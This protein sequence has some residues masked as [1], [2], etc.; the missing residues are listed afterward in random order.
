MRKGLKATS[1]FLL[2]II[3]LGASM[4]AAY[5]RPEEQARIEVGDIIVIK[6]LRGRAFAL[7]SNSEEPV[8]A[9]MTIECEV[10]S[11]E[12][13]LVSAEIHEGNITIQEN[14]FDV[15]NG[16]VRARLGKFGWILIRG[17]TIVDDKQYRFRFEGMLHVEKPG[18]VV[19]GLVGGLRG[20]ELSYRINGIGRAIKLESANNP[21]T[22]NL[23]NLLPYV[24]AISGAGL[25]SN[26]H[27]SV[28]D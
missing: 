2:A 18:L 9:T 25:L 26:F 16:T 11:V 23:P 24:H 3:L 22:I 19:I 4:S 17:L 13:R 14:R 1:L 10:V 27:L 8:N 28:V 5:S 6:F 21:S 7:E 12:N 20:E 15:V